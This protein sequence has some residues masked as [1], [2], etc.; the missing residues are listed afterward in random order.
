MTNMLSDSSPLALARRTVP[1]QES[2]IREM[3]RLG[4][5]TGAVNLSQGLPDYPSPPEVLAAAAEAV[6][7]GDNQYTFPFG[8]AAFRDAIA[9]KTLA[10]NKIAADPA[11]DVTV[12][13][14]VSEALMATLLA[15]T[16]PGDEVII[17]EPWYE[18]YVPDCQMV[19]VIPRFVPLREPDYTIDF[20]ELRRAFTART[21]LILLNTPHNPT[22]KVFSLAELCEIARLCCQ[23]GV[24]AVTDEIYEMILY[25]EHVHTS[26]GSL[27]GMHDRTVTISGLGKTYAL[28]GWRVGWIVADSRLSSLIRKVHDYL[29][30][31]APAPFQAA[32]IAALGLPDAFY[33]RLRQEYL[34]RKALLLR[35]LDETG[36]T[37][38]APQGAY[39]VMADFS[40]VRWQ[41]QKYSRAGWTLDRAFAEWAARDAGVAFVPGSSFYANGGGETRVRINFAKQEATLKEAARRLRAA[42]GRQA[43]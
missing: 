19:G 35:A 17:L 24:I 3:T 43:D 21:R 2:V 33:Q 10:Y 15:L 16:E 1:F 7:A 25:G 39:Y 6:L 4:E 18:S 42:A 41:P 34:T 5:V 38:L 8:T 30:I 20:D 14:G 36:F 40:N 12:T 9:R 31:C 13:C 26:I 27:P 29:T 11:T 32:G 23:H 28:T 22:G 37:Y